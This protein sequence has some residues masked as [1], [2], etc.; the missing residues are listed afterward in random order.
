MIC[1]WRDDASCDSGRAAS[2]SLLPFV[3]FMVPYRD[4]WTSGGL[5]LSQALRELLY[6]I[7]VVGCRRSCHFILTEENETREN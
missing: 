4:L 2:V 5:L 3:T 7:Q 6:V 1:L